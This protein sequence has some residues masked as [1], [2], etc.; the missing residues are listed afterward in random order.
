MPENGFVP[1]ALLRFKFGGE[2][3]TL[4][5]KTTLL[6]RESFLTICWNINSSPVLFINFLRYTLAPLLK[7]TLPSKPATLQ[8]TASLLQQNTS[9]TWMISTNYNLRLILCCREMNV[10]QSTTARQK[11]EFRW[12]PDNLGVPLYCQNVTGD[13]KTLRPDMIKSALLVQAPSRPHPTVCF[14]VCFTLHAK[15]PQRET[16]I[17]VYPEGPFGA[18]CGWK[19]DSIR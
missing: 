16:E 19:L 4:F 12:L 7:S 10:S 1:E 2:K 5:A 9:V 18:W 13:G 14:S 8:T 17:M 6:K 11:R 3:I 15:L